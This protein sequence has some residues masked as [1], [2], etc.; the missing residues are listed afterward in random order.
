MTL[1]HLFWTVLV[2]ELLVEE[3][4]LVLPLDLLRQQLRLMAFE[5]T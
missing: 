3:L 5:S 2:E 4:P 1:V